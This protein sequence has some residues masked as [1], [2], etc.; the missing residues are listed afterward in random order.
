MQ[1][2]HIIGN[3]RAGLICAAIAALGAPLHA[4]VATEVSTVGDFA[5][6]VYVQP[7]LTEEDLSILRMIATSQEALALFVPDAAGFS[8]MA[9]SPDDGFIKDG[10]PVASVV[11]LGGLPDAATALANAAAACAAAASTETA[12]VPLL[13]IAP[14]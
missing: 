14:K 6:T 13:E 10:V 5:I 7:F 3:A 11:A 4:Q 1:G 2:K 9:A 8:A 12:C